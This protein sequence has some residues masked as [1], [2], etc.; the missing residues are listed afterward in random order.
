MG[1][2]LA[3]PGWL[4]HVCT[5]LR[6]VER[7]FV[8][9]SP[10]S[11]DSLPRLSWRLARLCREGS[12]PIPW[13]NMVND[14]TICNARFP[15]KSRH[16]PRRRVPPGRRAAWPPPPSRGLHQR[17]RHVLHLDHAAQPR[18]HRLVDRLRVRHVL[19]PHPGQQEEVRLDPGVQIRHELRPL[20]VGLDKLG[21]IPK[22][23]IFHHQKG[24]AY[25]SFGPPWWPFFMLPIL[26]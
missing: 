10:S 21:N 15:L 17:L 18:G 16:R 20:L 25:F 14:W 26:A 19:R 11:A 9:L 3:C 5:F 22:R 2:V 4:C 8:H 1:N 23:Y 13:G 24:T 12:S 7:T 6:K